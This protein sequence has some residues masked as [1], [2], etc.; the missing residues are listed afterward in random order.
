MCW[1]TI[2]GGGAADADEDPLGLVMDDI[3]AH[4]GANGHAFG[5]A[6]AI[7]GELNIYKGVGYLPDRDQVRAQVDPNG[8][9]DIAIGHT[10]LATA[11]D[12]SGWNAH[13]FPI[14]NE[15]G[16]IVAA[17][18][19]NGTWYGA[20]TDR[21]GWCDS[22][23]IARDLEGRYQQLTDDEGVDTAREDFATLVRQTGARTGQTII[24]LHRDGRAFAH[25]GRFDITVGDDDI[26]LEE[27]GSAYDRMGQDSITTLSDGGRVDPKLATWFGYND[28]EIS[29]EAYDRV[30]PSDTAQTVR[31]SGGIQIPE[32]TVVRVD[33]R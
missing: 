33:Q 24:V 25:A 10:R 1:M 17:L 21:S 28:D 8:K 26:A 5:V 9:A 7:E 29:S 11:G 15:A 14:Y 2:R 20:P 16:E 13:P 12:R 32:T 3:E 31:S 18:A 23:Y 19:H 22:Y 30:A 6:V 27:L 4:E